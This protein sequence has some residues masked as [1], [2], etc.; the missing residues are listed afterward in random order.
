MPSPS[1]AVGSTPRARHDAAVQTHQAEV[2]RHN[3][4]VAQFAAGLR[5]RDRE[6]VQYYLELALSGTLLPD[7]VPHAVEVAYSPR[8]EQVVLRFELPSMDVIPELESYT[9]IEKTQR[10]ARKHVHR[11]RLHGSTVR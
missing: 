8:G 11:P 4:A 10:D 9:Y 7:D 5:E 1:I 2:A 6:S 3:N